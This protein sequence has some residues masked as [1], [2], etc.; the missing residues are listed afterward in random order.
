[1]PVFSAEAAFA[2]LRHQV[3]L[4][5]RAPGT[6]GHAAQL[7]WMRTWLAER[8]DT[9]VQQ[10][11]EHTRRDGRSITLTNLFA[12]FHPERRERLLLL[13]HWD[14]RPTADEDPDPDARG[15]P[16]PGANDGASGT[17]V[18]LELADVLSRHSPPI[19]VDLLFVDGEDFAPGEM[20][21]GAQHFAANLPRGYS[22]LYGVLVDMV[23]D[24]DP[25]FPV[26]E[27]SWRYAPEVVSRVW[28][29]AEELGHGSRFPRQVGSSVQDDHIPLNRA[30][31]PTVNI[32]DFEY[33]PGNRYWHTHAD[34]LENVSPVG[35]G[36]VGEVLAALVYRGG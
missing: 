21:L 5:P 2:H 17:A 31:I 25:R 16:I 28:A 36:V 19:G 10:P 29:V 35:L 18:L 13:A 27:N 34:A 6:P 4:G 23:G 30:G 22:P 3:E 7:A 11:F 1:M 20:Y 14:T 26:E 24:A 12:R 8:A 15:R 32:I 33:G 9:L